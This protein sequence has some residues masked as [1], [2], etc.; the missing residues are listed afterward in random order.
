MKHRYYETV[1][2]QW[3][4]IWGE[5][6]IRII[7]YGQ[8]LQTTSSSSSPSLVHVSVSLLH[9]TSMDRMMLKACT[10]SHKFTVLSP[11]IDVFYAEY[12]KVRLTLNDRTHRY[13]HWRPH[14]RRLLMNG[15]T[16][17]LSDSR[18]WTISNR[19]LNTPTLSELKL[20]LE[21]SE[22]GSTHGSGIWVDQGCK[23]ILKKTSILL[24]N[25]NLSAECT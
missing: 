12:G 4:R 14:R 18:L 25:L 17:V 6:F 10:S 24:V 5:I 23:P 11:N 20:G 7:L 1:T 8:L 9:K 19:W 3:G 21:V 22:G 16:P 13:I 2:C 15:G